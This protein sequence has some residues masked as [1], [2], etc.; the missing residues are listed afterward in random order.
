M[1]F[2]HG[3]DPELRV[4]CMLER[5]LWREKM[6]N[7]LINAIFKNFLG[8]ENEGYEDADF[9]PL[10]ASNESSFNGNTL[11]LILIDVSG[12]MNE[13]DYP[14][15]R[16]SAAKKASIGFLTKLLDKNPNGIVGIV[17]FSYRAW[18]VHQ[19][20]KVSKCF[21]Q[22]K[23]AINSLEI[24]S[25]TNTSAGLKLCIEIVNKFRTIIIDKRILALTDGHENAGGDPEI[26]AQELKNS[27][28]QIDIIGIGG[29]PRD[30]N[31]SKLKRMASVVDWELRYWFIESVGDLIRKFEVLA[32]R[33]IK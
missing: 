1:I 26:P 10:P 8:C 12:S 14:P 23:D 22:L 32:L 7:R 25:N 9:Q 31:E 2:M 5:A 13:K 16:L 28:I 24:K 33:E 17:S 21:S 18:I 30:V 6:N 19:P 15:S 20:V 27:G 4:T 29:S 11:D 3:K